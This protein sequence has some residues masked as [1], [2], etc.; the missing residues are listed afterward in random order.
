LAGVG[1]IQDENENAEQI[2]AGERGCRDETSEEYREQN[3]AAA[4]DIGQ[5]EP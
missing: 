5:V 1:E 3:E 2:V 4:R